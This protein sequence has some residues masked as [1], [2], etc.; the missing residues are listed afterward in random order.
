MKDKPIL[1]ST[2]MVQAI[3][4]GRKTQTRRIV[5]NQDLVCDDGTIN[6]NRITDSM[7]RRVN[8]ELPESFGLNY[9]CPYGEPGNLLW[10]R[11]SFTEE[12]CATTYCYKADFPI[13]WPPEQ[14]EE[15]EEIIQEAKDYRFKPSIHMPRWASRITLEVT[16]VRVERLDDIT[17]SDAQAEGVLLPATEIDG[18]VMALL[19]IDGYAPKEWTH[20]EFFKRLWAEINGAESWAANPWVWVVEFNPICCNINEYIRKAA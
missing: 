14:T 3:I 7:W 4:A 8:K 19:P 17:E 1:F 13:I 18:E 6:T 5:K 10:V 12:A 11:E 20:R 15:G 16:G 9:F 2:P